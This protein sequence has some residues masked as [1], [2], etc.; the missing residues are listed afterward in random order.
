IRAL[1]MS[2][3]MVAKEQAHDLAIEFLHFYAPR[4]YPLGPQWVYSWKTATGA[5]PYLLEFTNEPG[6]NGHDRFHAYGANYAELFARI[7]GLDS[8]LQDQGLHRWGVYSVDL[9]LAYIYA[10]YLYKMYFTTSKSIFSTIPTVL[11]VVSYLLGLPI[12]PEAVPTG[13]EV[14]APDSWMQS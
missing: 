4:R 1:G 3:P 8:V 7:K 14:E 2:L 12:P 13:Q 9:V 6:L 5:L 11:G 10:D